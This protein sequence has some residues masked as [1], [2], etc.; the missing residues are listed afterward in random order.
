MSQYCNYLQK[1]ITQDMHMIIELK[2][3]NL[4]RYFLKL[5]KINVKI[6]STRFGNIITINAYNDRTKTI[7]F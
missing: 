2:Q 3:L 7:K 1:I 6:L 4:R 5:N